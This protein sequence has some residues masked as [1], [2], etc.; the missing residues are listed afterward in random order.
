MLCWAL[1]FF[2][3]W[4]LPIYFINEYLC[5]RELYVEPSSC[6]D[7]WHWE[8]GFETGFGKYTYAHFISPVPA[9]CERIQNYPLRSGEQVIYTIKVPE[10]GWYGHRIVLTIKFII[11]RQGTIYWRTLPLDRLSSDFPIKS[12]NQKYLYMRKTLPYI[13]SPIITEPSRFLSEAFSR[14]EMLLWKN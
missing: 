5:G 13:D 1:F 4:A 9:T 2:F 8:Y 11:Y 7:L 14:P 10:G 3:S 12:N 6:L